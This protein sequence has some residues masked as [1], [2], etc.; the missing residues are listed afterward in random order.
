VDEVDTRIMRVQL[1]HSLHNSGSEVEVRWGDFEGPES[2]SRLRRIRDRLVGEDRFRMALDLSSKCQLEC[3][4]VWADWARALVVMGQ[5]V[6]L[7][8]FR[9]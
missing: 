3:A 4:S 6:S 5:C 2:T 9:C 7:L 1:M 8:H